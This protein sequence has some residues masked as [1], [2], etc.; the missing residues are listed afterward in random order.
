MKEKVQLSHF[1]PF[2]QSLRNQVVSSPFRPALG[3]IK[4]GE[5]GFGGKQKPMY[6]L[7]LS[8][9]LVEHPKEPKSL[10]KPTPAVKIL[11]VKGNESGPKSTKQKKKHCDAFGR[12]DTSK[13]FTPFRKEVVANP[14]GTTLKCGMKSI[15]LSSP[16]F[17]LTDFREFKAEGSMPLMVK[18]PCLSANGEDPN[19]VDG[20]A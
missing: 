10:S 12:K 4:A 16:D 11:G 6:S 13:K 8:V 18:A 15:S 9:S 17:V 1:G 20:D 3:S 7:D 5:D 19:M 14:F 2:D